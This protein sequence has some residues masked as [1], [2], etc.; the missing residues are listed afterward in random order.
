[1]L[2]QVTFKNTFPFEAKQDK[3]FLHSQ[4]SDCLVVTQSDPVEACFT[5]MDLIDVHHL[6]KQEDLKLLV[7]HYKHIRIH[8]FN[9]IK[10]KAGG[11]LPCMLIFIC[12]L[13]TSYLVKLKKYLDGKT[14]C[15][16]MEI[17]V[18]LPLHRVF[19]III[20]P[21]CGDFAVGCG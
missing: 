13:P 14:D 5:T 8:S 10:G 1:M 17:S 21:T 18:Q 9:V 11:T 7:I 20:V 15:V 12:I 4:D 2:F 3:F 19:E 6:P 16:S